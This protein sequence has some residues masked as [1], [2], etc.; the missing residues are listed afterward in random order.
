MHHNYVKVSFI[1]A[2]MLLI[3]S[4]T[5][6]AHTDMCTFT[7]DCGCAVE[8]NLA[9]QVRIREL[10]DAERQQ[11]ALCPI[12]RFEYL[13]GAIQVV[14]TGTATRQPLLTQP[15]YNKL[16]DALNDLLIEV[17]SHPTP[18]PEFLNE[19]WARHGPAALYALKLWT[20][21]TTHPYLRV[22]AIAGGYPPRL[23]D[24]C[25]IICTYYQ[26]VAQEPATYPEKVT[27]LLSRQG[28]LVQRAAWIRLHDLGSAGRDTLLQLYHQGWPQSPGSLSRADFIG[29]LAFVL[30][31][32]GDPRLSQV[33]AADM[34]LDSVATLRTYHQVHFPVAPGEIDVKVGVAYMLDEQSRSIAG[35]ESM[36]QMTTP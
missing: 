25:E 33:S 10:S 27:Y 6:P 12:A 11:V 36:Y 2:A 31:R 16:T 5:A 34:A 19:V 35:L 23:V 28:G 1:I 26:I 3:H 21:G 17:R 4:G 18:R 15:T 7:I 22:L 29:T 9:R 8:F 20:G 24:H 13:E 14:K 32:A 30:D